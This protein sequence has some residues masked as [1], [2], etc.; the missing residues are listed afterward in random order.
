MFSRWQYNI[1]KFHFS[2]SL[3]L[4]LSI[5]LSLS[6]S[7]HVSAV[8]W[9]QTKGGDDV[10]WKLPFA[11]YPFTIFKWASS[12]REKAFLVWSHLFFIFVRQLG[13][14]FNVG[15][16]EPEILIV[17]FHDL[18]KYLPKNSPKLARQNIFCL[19]LVILGNGVRDSFLKNWPT[20]SSFL[21]PSFQTE[22]YRK[23]L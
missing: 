17:C 15:S 11:A 20:P 6:L 7:Q 10:R 4:S 13:R 9:D 1:C 8:T 22:I 14:R 12:F 16:P 5:S 18:P 23:K 19:T 2:I 3:S 21:F